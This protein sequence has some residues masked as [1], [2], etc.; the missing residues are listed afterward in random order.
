ASNCENRGYESGRITNLACSGNEAPVT[1]F[2]SD[3]P[4]GKR[5]CCVPKIV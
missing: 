1:A 3:V 2:M 5:C 4:E